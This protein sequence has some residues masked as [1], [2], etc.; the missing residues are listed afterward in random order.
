[1]GVNLGFKVH[2]E[3]SRPWSLSM[4]FFSSS[5]KY[6]RQHAINNNDTEID[7]IPIIVPEFLASEVQKTF[8]D[9]CWTS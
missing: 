9:G 3:L 4:S 7:S 8:V 5:E 6:L 2:Y 1:M